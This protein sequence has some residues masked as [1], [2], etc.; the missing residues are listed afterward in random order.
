[1]FVEGLPILKGYFVIMVVVDRLSKYAH[2]MS[3]KHPFIVAQMALLFLNNVFK[4]HGLPKTIV[5]DHG[6]TFTTSFWREHFRLQWV[7]LSILQP[8]ILKVMAKQK[9]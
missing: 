5:S 2:F 8:I 3:L 6:S 7:N 9:L 4:L 1:M